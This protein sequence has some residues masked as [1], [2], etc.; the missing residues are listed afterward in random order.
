MITRE[1]NVPSNPD[2]E[3]LARYLTGLVPYVDRGEAYSHT[4]DP[5]T[6]WRALDMVHVALHLSGV[7][8]W[9]TESYTGGAS[10]GADR[11]RAER[12]AGYGDPLALN[13]LRSVQPFAQVSFGPRRLVVGLGDRLED[14]IRP[15]T[16]P[17]KE[18]GELTATSL[19]M[20]DID[21]ASREVL[22][23]LFRLPS[24]YDTEFVYDGL[25]ENAFD[26]TKEWLQE[27]EAVLAERRAQQPTPTSNPQWP[28]I[29]L[30][31][32]PHLYQ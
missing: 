26:T 21:P 25:P 14:H 17:S 23:E 11:S 5:G 30:T 24:A 20:S 22:G 3:L 10:I 4:P 18:P 28:N 15:A 13:A 31:L 6:Y 9:S 19:R 2:R 16:H 7:R 32:P 12:W 8:V 27:N 29:T 1:Y